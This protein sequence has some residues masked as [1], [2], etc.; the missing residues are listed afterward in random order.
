M[1]S[2]ATSALPNR[3]APLRSPPQRSDAG[4]VKGKKAMPRLSS[5]VIMFQIFTPERFS[6]LPG[7]QV[8]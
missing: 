8:S 2:T 4:P 6:V 3:L 5:T 1:A 7:S